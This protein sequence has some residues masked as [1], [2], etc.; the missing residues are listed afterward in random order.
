[1]KHCFY[2]IG[3]ADAAMDKELLTK[4]GVT[5][6]LT[7]A[8][9]KDYKPPLSNTRHMCLNILD[10]PQTELSDYYMQAF[11]FIEECISSNGKV[12]IHCNAGVSRSAAILIAYLMK[13][14]T[15]SYDAAWSI[16]KEKRPN[17]NPNIGF[18]FQLK[19]YEKQL[20]N[21]NN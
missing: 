1:M 3:S 14:Q 6:I 19:N 4:Y 17:I 21:I 18:I 13:T 16:V 8:P 20:N 15:L 10:L 5:H 12:L 9:L 2:V 11:T 7:V